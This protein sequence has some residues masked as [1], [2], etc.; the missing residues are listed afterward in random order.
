MK[1]RIIF[2]SQSATTEQH[3]TQF[4]KNKNV[5]LIPWNVM[6]SQNHWLCIIR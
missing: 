3:S 6:D 4:D 2:S 1:V 5:I